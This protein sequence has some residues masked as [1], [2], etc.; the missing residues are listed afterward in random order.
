MI[1][2]PSV[3]AF[4]RADERRR[5]SRELDFGVWWYDTIDRVPWRVSWVAATGD[6]Y[7]VR[8][9]P[10]RIV[11]GPAG[12]AILGGDENGPVIRIAVIEIEA[13]LER[14]LHGWPEHCGHPGGLAWVIGAARETNHA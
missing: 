3:E 8:L 12:L 10:A 2:F 13:E 4:Y 5:R 14:R 9:G 11:Q 1:T 7:I 6:V